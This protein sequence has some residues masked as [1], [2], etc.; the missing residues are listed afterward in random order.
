MQGLSLTSLRG[1]SGTI[2]SLT[3][4]KPNPDGVNPSFPYQVASG[5]T[6]FASIDVLASEIDYNGAG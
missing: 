4:C 3:T 6:R 1:L 2:L 5:A